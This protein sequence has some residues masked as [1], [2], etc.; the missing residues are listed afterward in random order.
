MQT[1]TL[2]ERCQSGGAHEAKA[3]DQG[4]SGRLRETKMYGGAGIRADQAGTRI[5]A[6]SITRVAQST[7]GVGSGLYDTQ[8][9][10]VSQDILRI[11]R[12]RNT[13]VNG[14]GKLKTDAP[15][16]TNPR[17]GPTIK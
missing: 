13:T 2:T 7:R 11:K 4:G 12:G 9:P 10:E 5:P 1:G 14:Y 17:S 8:S 6:V 16:H 3:E 15:E